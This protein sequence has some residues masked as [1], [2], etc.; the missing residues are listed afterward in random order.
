MKFLVISIILG[1]SSTFSAPTDKK[2]STSLIESDK[3]VQELKN[4]KFVSGLC[5]KSKVLDSYTDSLCFALYDVAL[6]FNLKNVKLIGLDKDENTSGQENFCS[7]LENELPDSPL[8]SENRAS[9][10]TSWLKDVL[11]EKDGLTQCTEKCFYTDPSDYS[12]KVKPVC[13][14]LYKQLT[15]VHLLDKQV[16]EIALIGELMSYILLN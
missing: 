6:S 10:Q 8:N 13:L 9:N 15:I 5:I 7:K 3:R 12:Q 2:T 1:I 14:F 16:K 4:Q 11:K